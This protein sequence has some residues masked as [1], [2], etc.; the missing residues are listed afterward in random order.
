LRPAKGI[1]L[2]A[3]DKWLVTTTGPER[4]L[5]VWSTRSCQF[6]R[7]FDV[8]LKDVDW[9]ELAHDGKNI[10][11]GSTMEEVIKVFDF[12]SGQPL[13]EFPFAGRSNSTIGSVSP[14]GRHFAFYQPSKALVRIV[15][16]TNFAEVAT[17]KAPLQSLSFIDDETMIF[18]GTPHQLEIY[19]LEKQAVTH[20]FFATAG[21]TANVA[22]SGDRSKVYV[23]SELNETRVGFFEIELASFARVLHRGVDA[24]SRNLATA[25]SNDGKLVVATYDYGKAI[26]GLWR[27]E[28]AMPIL[29]KGHDGT[30]KD[31]AI[32]PDNKM[33]AAAGD[34]YKITLWDVESGEVLRYLPAAGYFNNRLRF[35]R[36][37]NILLA[38]SGHTLNGILIWDMK[39]NRALPTPNFGYAFSADLSPDGKNL[40]VATGDGNIS[41]YDISQE[42]KLY[43]LASNLRLNKNQLITLSPDGQLLAAIYP[44]DGVVEVWNLAKQSLERSLYAAQKGFVDVKFSQDKR[45]VF[46]LNAERQRVSHWDIKEGS[47]NSAFV[48]KDHH[49]IASFNIADTGEKVIAVD[50]TILK[51]RP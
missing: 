16:T 23:S 26:L 45:S 39:T 1:A 34:G 4:E 33:I 49:E 41:V 3:D 19:N 29:L 35:S 30:I 15:N 7:S 51:T 6:E 46:A 2:S 28:V 44:G 9:I 11:V 47:S 13:V 8:G 10:F 43:T 5:G 14:S 20:K 12:V 24:P 32:S 42:T 21:N 27:D 50:N 17:V 40:F 38:S 37:G 36:E 18:S 22:V 31:I 25:I 48:V